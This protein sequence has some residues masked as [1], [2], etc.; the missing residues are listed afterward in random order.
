MFRTY[1]NDDL[2]CILKD[3]SDLYDDAYK[4]CNF[5]SIGEKNNISNTV[6][7]LELL[8]FRLKWLCESILSCIDYYSAS[9]LYR[10]QI[11]HSFKHIYICLSCLDNGDEIATD[12]VSANHFS[13]EAIKKM[14]KILWLDK[15]S[16]SEKFG[17][18]KEF[19]EFI[20]QGD[21]TTSKFRFDE[22]T[23]NILELLSNKQQSGLE[24]IQE[25]SR[26][27]MAG[28]ST[29][30]S[31]VHAGPTA[32]LDLSEKP[33]INIALDSKIMTIVAYQYTIFLL[34]QYQSE[35]QEELK[36]INDNIYKKC[37]N[38]YMIHMRDFEEKEK[39]T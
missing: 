13:G 3:V 37:E 7:V 10:A 18:T 39:S 19:K 24:K 5:K 38:A 25:L 28:Y 14:R 22:V 27:L 36:K 11:E 29:L 1:K 16:I 31:F 8:N 4:N 9:I 21:S 32:V 30:S 15:L 23:K 12:Y 34:S 33:K 2:Y 26:H 6:W 35:H 20:K 17:N